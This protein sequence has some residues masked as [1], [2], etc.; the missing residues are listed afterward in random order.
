MCSRG[1]GLVLDSGRCR[2]HVCIGRG[3]AARLVSL[4]V[5]LW[6]LCEETCVEAIPLVSRVSPLGVL[7]GGG[8]EG[9]SW[10]GDEHETYQRKQPPRRV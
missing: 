10:G 2:M 4:R 3:E 9:N 8:D 7:I 1:E 6:V 5:I